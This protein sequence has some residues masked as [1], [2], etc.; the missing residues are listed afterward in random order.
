VSAG[1]ATTPM[2]P[3]GIRTR[4]LSA[5]R[6]GAGA[7]VSFLLG[8]SLVFALVLVLPTATGYRSLTVLTGSMEPTLETGS[9]VVDEV[10]QPTEARI[11]DI[12]TFTDPANRDRQITH[13]LRSVRVEGNTAHMVTKGDANDTAERWD[14]PVDGEVGRVIFHVPKLG[15]VRALVGTRQG[16]IVLM[17]AILV[18]G[19]WVLTDVWRRPAR[20]GD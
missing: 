19:G 11:G 8:A 4:A 18:L 1:T 17:L 9:V 2:T 5:L 14:I 3:T 20:E 7:I 13:R 15:H 16:Y 12:V 10:I 6:L